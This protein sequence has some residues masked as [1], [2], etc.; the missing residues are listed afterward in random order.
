MRRPLPEPPVATPS[1]D[2]SDSQETRSIS[3]AS[4]RTFG[5]DSIL[6]PST[7]GTTSAL[8]N[9]PPT[10]RPPTPSS[11]ESLAGPSPEE[12][13]EPPVMYNVQTPTGRYLVDSWYLTPFSRYERVLIISLG[14]KLL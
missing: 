7:R 4:S 10:T 9:Q 14:Y 13:L 1:A 12:N 2:P 8:P 5:S 3:G 6:P 11:K